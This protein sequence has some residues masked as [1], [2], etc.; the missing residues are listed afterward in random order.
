KNGSPLR[1]SLKDVGTGERAGFYAQT[2]PLDLGICPVLTANDRQLA[3]KS[4][5]YSTQ[6][7]LFQ[8][9]AD[10][11]GHALIEAG[12]ADEGLNARKPHPIPHVVAH[13]G[14]AYRDALV[15]QLFDQT[16]QRVAGTGI[17][18]VHRICVQKHVL[19]WRVTSCQRRP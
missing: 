16:Q 18:K 13:T 2:W 14:K 17:N 9:D 12:P 8:P 15:L 6:V 4:G 19:H 5:A 1:S 11:I 10:A 7:V 3:P